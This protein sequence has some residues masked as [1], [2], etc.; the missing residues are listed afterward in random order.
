MLLRTTTMQA[1][2]AMS[3]P[4]RPRR[5]NRENGAPLCGCRVYTDH[6]VFDVGAE[7]VRIR[8]TYGI[9]A[10]ELAHRLAITSVTDARGHVSPTRR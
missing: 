9:D 4:Y 10:D 3:G 1:S 2:W 5:A 6:D 8:E 7:G